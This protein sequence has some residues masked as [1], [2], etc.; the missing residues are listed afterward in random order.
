MVGLEWEKLFNFE[1][2]RLMEIALS[3]MFQRVTTAS[4]FYKSK[5]K[6]LNV[7]HASNCRELYQ[8]TS[9]GDIQNKLKVFLIPKN[10][11]P[12]EKSLILY[13]DAHESQFC[14]ACM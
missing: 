11:R 8:I 5:G 14:R 3:E 2:A 13:E 9:I 12:E 1:V 4:L 10:N 7:S 6:F